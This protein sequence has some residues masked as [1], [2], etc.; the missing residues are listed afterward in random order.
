MICFHATFLFYY[1][2]I[3]FCLQQKLLKILLICFNALRNVSFVELALKYTVFSVILKE[4]SIF[5]NTTTKVTQMNDERKDFIPK[6]LQQIRLASRMTQNKLAK[7][8]NVSRSCLANYETGKRSPDSD[9]LKAMA[10]FYSVETSYFT[11]E[12]IEVLSTKNRIFF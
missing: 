10:N 4:S 6:K 2:T 3:V 11:K 5:L 1:S 12:E 7:E 9:I 8:L